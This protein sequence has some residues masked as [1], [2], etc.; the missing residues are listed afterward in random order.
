MML[1]HLSPSEVTALEL[2]TGVPIAYELDVTGEV[3]IKTIL[4]D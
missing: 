2:A 1:D 4:N 3:V